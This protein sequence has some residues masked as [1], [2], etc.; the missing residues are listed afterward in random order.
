MKT[1][2]HFAIVYDDQCPLCSAYTLWFVRGKWIQQAD[3]IS[4]SEIEKNKWGEWIDISRAKN[5]IPVAE[6]Q[7][8]TIFYGVEGLTK[9]LAQRYPVIERVAAIS[10]VKYFL[11]R[12]YKII[13]FNRRIIVPAKACHTKFDCAPDFNLKYRISFMILSAIISSIITFL[14][15][16]SVNETISNNPWQSGFYFLLIS[17]TG[18]VLQILFVL[19]LKVRTRFSRTGI[20]SIPMKS[21]GRVREGQAFD[22]ASHLSVIMLAGVLVLIPSIA[23]N[24]LSG[25]VILPVT[26][27]SLCISGGVMFLQHWKRVRLLGISKWWNALWLMSLYGGA[28]FWIFFLQLYKP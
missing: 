8:G 17:G 27:L 6:L 23:I 2:R 1:N 24:F 14:F 13:S 10:P 5:E 15:G 19:F 9:I 21:G 25:H 11:S 7:S 4:F 18:W 22:Y 12:L 26:I 20:L 3:R 16:A 28:L